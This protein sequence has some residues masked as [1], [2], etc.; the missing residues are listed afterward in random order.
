[1]RTTITIDRKN[2]LFM[3]WDRRDILEN[4]FTCDIEEEKLDHLMNKATL[5]EVKEYIKNKIE[6]N[7]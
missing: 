7:I 4:S 6:E 5:D 1:M 3:V 2:E